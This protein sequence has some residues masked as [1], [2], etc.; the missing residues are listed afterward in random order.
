[1]KL[2]ISIALLLCLM[3]STF[4][5]VTA[6]VEDAVKRPLTLTDVVDLL[7]AGV[8]PKRVSAIVHQ[9]GV[10]FTLTDEAEKQ[11]RAAGGDDSVV[12]AAAKSHK[13]P[14]QQGNA[15]AAAGAEKVNAKDGLKYVWIPAGTFQMGCSPGDN[16]CYADEKPAHK[17]TISKGFWMGQT[18]V[19]QAAYQRVRGSNPSHFHGDQLPVETVTWDDANGYCAAAGMRLPTEAESEYAARAGDTASRYGDVDAISWYYKNSGAQTHDVGQK[20]PNAW[21]LYDMLGNVW[22]WTS[23]WYDQDYYSQSP[24]QDPRGPSSGT[25]RVMRGGSWNDFARLVRVSDRGVCLPAVRDN[26][27]GFRCAGEVP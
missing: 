6:Q 24:S 1:M 17:I 9:R 12:I 21:K 14:A 11:I 7:K 8:S 20:Q 27:V 26:D 13:T 4:S 19:T 15:V 22:E 18:L 2:K 10:D 25:Y 23:D 16:E 5:I 3:V